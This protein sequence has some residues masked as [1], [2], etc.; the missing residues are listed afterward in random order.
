[1]FSKIISTLRA[2]ITEPSLKRLRNRLLAVNLVSLTLVVVVAFSLIYIDYY[3]R[4]QNEILKTLDSIPPGVFENVTLAQKMM[5]EADAKKMTEE[6]SISVIGGTVVP[7]DYSKCFVA[8]VRDD[9]YITVFSMLDI[10]NEDCLYAVE[11][12][13]ESGASSGSLE[14]AERQWQYSM[15]RSS[16]QAQSDAAFIYERSIVFLDV[17]EMSQG[18]RELAI[19]LFVIGFLAIGAILLVS[20]LVANRAIRPVQENMDRQKRFIADASHELKTPIAVIAANAEAAKDAANRIDSSA[21]T[22]NENVSSVTR[23]IDN[24]TDE[25]HH[26]NGL[27]KS[28]LALAKSEEMKLNITTFDLFEAIRAEADRVETFLFEKNIFFVLES[29]ANENDPLL[30]SSDQAKVQSILSVL[31]ENAVK[32]TPEGGRVTITAGRAKNAGKPAISVCVA[33]S[34]TGDYIPPEDIARV[35]DRFFRADRS[36][37][38]ETGGHGIGLSIAKEMAKMIGGDLTAASDKNPDGSAINT[39]TLYI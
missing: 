19:S 26:M 31:F 38:S 21:F 34:N 39:F 14:M 6:E 35:F 20:L 33:V 9:G 23:W 25:A 16:G 2:S 32:Y 36:R 8:N 24:I 1:M 7:V 12:V 10:T 37:N 5:D 28:L 27:I 30:V 15:K 11:T 17:E 18:M 13:M 3:N 22:E 4:T 29:P